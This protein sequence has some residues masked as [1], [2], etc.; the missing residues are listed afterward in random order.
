MAAP[1]PLLPHVIGRY[2]LYG[3]IAAGGMAT[4]HFGRLL[5][6]AGFSRTVAIKRLHPQFAKDPEFVSMFLDEAR[7]AGRVRHPNVVQTLDV[8][9]LDGELFLVMDY[10]QG[11]SLGRLVRV[12]SATKQAVPL[13]VVSAILCGALQGLHAAHEA[14]SEQGEP[15]NIVHRDISPQNILIGADGLPRLLDFGIAKAAG[16]IHTTREGQVKGKLAYMAPETLLGRGIDRRADI[17]AAGVILWEILTRRRLF[18]GDSEGA[19][20]GSV[21]NSKIE[22]PSTLEP[23]VP[24][25][26]D[27]VTMRALDRD[28]AARFESA[29]QM[30]TA[31]EASVP[32]ASASAVTAWVESLAGEIL[33]RRAVALAHIESDSGISPAPMAGAA[34]IAVA[35]ASWTPG[36]E[37][38]IARSVDQTVIA[39]SRIVPAR[40]YG[41]RRVRIAAGLATGLL[42]AAL[43]LLALR[44]SG[45]PEPAALVPPS[46][47]SQAS[48][49][50]PPGSADVP[51]ATPATA[52]AT[53]ATSSASAAPAAARIHTHA[54]ARTASTPATMAS[55]K[56]CPIRSYVDESGITHFV[57]DCP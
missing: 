21:L 57:K 55:G 2:A 51:A 50:P 54:P 41:R 26:L 38:T 27:E 42:L 12:C 29:R 39:P 48:Q 40:A 20:V 49:P 18:T 10:V 19:V 23:T 11:E 43:A 5:G 15:L 3:Q 8:V 14:T 44:R 36:A 25:S 37:D 31:L 53:T 30:A 32:L 16:R 56:P 34:A 47:V 13:P 4:V 52:A 35:S 7:L 28:P 22:P 46:A 17:Y 24:G 9:A 1:H 45:D 33:A 6:P